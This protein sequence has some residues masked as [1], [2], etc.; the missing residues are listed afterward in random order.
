VA[1]LD[2]QVVR[3]LDAIAQREHPTA[4][5]VAADHGEGVNK[6]S[7]YH[8]DTLDEPVIRIP[9]IARVPGW[10]AGRV[11]QVAS[12]IDIV[13]SVLSLLGSPTPEYLDGVDLAP[14]AHKQKNLPQRVLFSDTW[15]YTFDARRQIDASAVYDGARKYILDRL[16]GNLSYESQVGVPKI[17]YVRSPARFVGTAPF[18][19]LSS[20]VFAYLEEAGTLSIQD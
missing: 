5:F 17:G 9:L 11:T 2:S 18:D 13:P 20:A 10:P 7:R 3:L 8:G 4:I 19:A 12:S 6:I 14:Y 1:F 15:R 16:T